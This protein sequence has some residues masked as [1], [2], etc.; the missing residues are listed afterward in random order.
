MDKSEVRTEFCKLSAQVA[1][2]VLT[3]CTV[4]ECK[5]ESVAAHMSG[6]H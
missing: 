1:E 6:K 3:A 5:G 4:S 2:G